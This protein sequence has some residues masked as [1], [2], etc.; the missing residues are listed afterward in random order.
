MTAKIDEKRF[1]K[2]QKRGLDS[3]AHRSVED[4]MCAMEAFSYIRRIRFTDHPPCVSPVIAGFMRSWNDSLPD[5]ERGIL[6]QLL[7]KLID[8]VN[9]D[10]EQRRAIMC[11]DW[12]VRVHTPAWLRL[13][14]LTDN[15]DALEALPE[16]TAFA[17]VPSI[18]G[19]LD[20]ARDAAR[21]AARA[22]ARDAAW[23]AAW[24]ALAPTKAK[25][26]QS[27]IELVERM[28]ALTDEV[29]SIAA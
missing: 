4:G 22:A 24:D 28:C 6:I 5:A 7:P 3:G 20:A 9:P 18:R 11:A 10:L 23:D 8:T 27:A 12:L 19:P 16:I 13:A 21:A 14:G 26:Q 1:A 15:A 25:L 29:Q 17:Q 2:V